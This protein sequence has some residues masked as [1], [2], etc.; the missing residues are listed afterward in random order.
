MK[1]KILKGTLIG[2][3]SYSMMMAIWI[4]C[5]LSDGHSLL[6]A[7]GAIYLIFAMLVLLKLM[8]LSKLNE[9]KK[10]KKTK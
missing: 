3:F 2:I 1:L 10:N 4:I 9:I 5:F 8:E 6:L 7:V